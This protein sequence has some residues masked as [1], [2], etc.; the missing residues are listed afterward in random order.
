MGEFDLID[1]FFRRPVRKA[2][3]GVGDDCAL[4]RTTPGCYIHDTDP[5]GTFEVSEAEREAFWEKLYAEPGFGIWV[6]NF[7]DVLKHALI[8]RLVRARRSAPGDAVR[9]LRCAGE[10]APHLPLRHPGGRPGRGRPRG[11]RRRGRGPDRG[12][13]HHQRN[14]LAGTA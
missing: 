4:L 8:V 2:M 1:R 14:R 9:A 5:R 3:L 6:G 13:H 11:P 7:A 10:D 12:K